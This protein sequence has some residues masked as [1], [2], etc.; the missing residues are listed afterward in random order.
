MPEAA[1]ARELA[2]CFTTLALVTDLDA[3]VEGEVGVT[4][5]EVLE[6]FAQNIEGLKAVL[7]DA[8]EGLPPAESDADATCA[9]RH[10]LDG[11]TLPFPL[12][13]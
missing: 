12:P 13:T 9:C 2:L 3:G 6:V 11:L 8:V 1:I 7:A 4:H 10:S 5:E